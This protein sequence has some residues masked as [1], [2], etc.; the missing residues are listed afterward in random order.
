MLLLALVLS[1]ALVCDKSADPSFGVRD[2]P[3]Q[4]PEDLE[5]NVII[6][7]L[8]IRICMLLKQR[9][10]EGG[11]GEKGF[12]RWDQAGVRL[13]PRQRSSGHCASKSS[14]T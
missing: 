6:L 3:A 2:K 11:E 9:V 1:L 5:L 4:G 7:M 12:K 14:A 8:V 13:G 10:E